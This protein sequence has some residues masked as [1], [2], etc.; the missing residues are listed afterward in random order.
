MPMDIH[1]DGTISEREPFGFGNDVSFCLN[2]LQSVI[3][4]STVDV[5]VSM[6][7]LAAAMLFNDGITCHGR[8]STKDLNFVELNFTK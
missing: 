6:T 7:S 2:Y 5:D 4:Q 1:L 8:G 3:V